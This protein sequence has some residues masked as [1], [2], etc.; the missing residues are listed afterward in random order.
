[1]SD[2]STIPKRTRIDK[3]DA[4]LKVV[5]TISLLATCDRGYAACVIVRDNRILTTG[6]VGSPPGMPHCDDVDHEM[7]T[8]TDAE[9]HSSEH[10]IRTIHAEQNA[11]LQAA[12]IGVSI[13]GATLYCRMTPCRTCAMFIIACGIKRVVCEKKYRSGDWTEREFQNA[14]IELVY[15]SKEIQKYAGEK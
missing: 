2:S 4:F 9:G 6:Y 13:Y 7:V 15:K 5:D 10:C 8:V 11:I 3:D 12:I 14:G 1:M